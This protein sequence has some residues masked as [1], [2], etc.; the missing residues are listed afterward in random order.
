MYLAQN[1]DKEKIPT[2]PLQYF[3]DTDNPLNLH[4]AKFLH[5]KN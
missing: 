5:L 2:L 1:E 3:P 4:M